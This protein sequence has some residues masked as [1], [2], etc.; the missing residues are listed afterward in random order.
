VAFGK[1]E[2]AWKTVEDALKAN[3][4]ETYDEIEASMDNL[5]KGLNNK[6]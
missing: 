4:P 6:D 2:D 1:F 5:S 3:S